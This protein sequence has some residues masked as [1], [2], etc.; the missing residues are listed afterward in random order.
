M[1]DYRDVTMTRISR[2]AA[3]VW[4]TTAMLPLLSGCLLFAG[5]HW[6]ETRSSV[7]EPIN[8]ALHRH[9]PRDITA[10]D[11]DAIVALY[12]THTGGGVG[13]DDPV[14][15]TDG[16]SEQRR[17]WQRGSTDE[18]IRERYERLLGL[19]A[20]IEKADLRIHRVH[21]D[22]R[23]DRGYPA[24]VHLIV[25][26]VAANG[27]RRVLDQ[28]ARVSIDRRNQ[29]WTIT[30]EDVTMRELISAAEPRFEAATE[31][32]GIDDTHDTSGS[33]T[34]R[35]I[36]D[37]AGSSGVAVADV[38]CDGFEDLALLSSSRLALYRN[39]ADGTFRDVTTAAGL[40]GGLDIAATGLVFFDADNDGDPDLW[41]CGIRGERFYRNDG[42]DRLVDASDAA[43]VK[44]SRWSSMPIVADYDRD[45][46]LDVF[47]VR[48][49]DHEKTAPTPNWNARNGVGA[50]L[51][52]ND[53]DGTFTDVTVAA[54]I[55]ETGWGLAG[56]WGDYNADG[57]PDIYVGNEF[58][59][60]SLYRNNGDGTFANVAAEAGA[61]DRGAAMGTAWGDYD[62]DGDLDIFVSNMY[63]NS[64]WALFHPE[65]PPPV[66][67]YFRWV[68]RS[69]VDAIIEEHTRGSTLLRNDGDGTFTDVSDAAGVRD[70]Q[71][72]WGAEFLDYNN[73]GR[74][75]IY[76]SNGFVTGPI[77]DDI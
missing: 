11:L 34:F 25:R 73:D 43:G 15:L 29:R 37:V 40:D 5:R 12:A 2:R 23:G 42:C 63:A 68:P 9:L 14:I 54:R 60:N 30:S 27:E 49:G 33:P 20:D 39:D 76:A 59:V 16:F 55:S 72:G 62:N 38:D 47:V 31:A 8:S 77:P 45:G 13:W 10:R 67:W 74:L 24:D 36:G 66:P 6:D 21:W 1:T 69:D 52:H 7:I 65:F 3:R 51:Y 4:M 75:D 56:G 22:Q 70:T 19:F 50:T 46:F 48:M 57:H 32:A 26:G 41:V 61:L 17:R 71:W 53:G 35:L 18:P 64:R 44:P 28:W 58:G